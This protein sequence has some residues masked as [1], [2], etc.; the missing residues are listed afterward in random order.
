MAQTVFFSCMQ[1]IQDSVLSGNVASMLP[2]STC[3]ATTMQDKE[4][5]MEGCCQLIPS[6]RHAEVVSDWAGLRPARD[7]VLLSLEH[8]QV[9]FLMRACS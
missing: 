9:S 7:R 1:D 6:L 2:Y 4:R 8:L 3:S 5:I